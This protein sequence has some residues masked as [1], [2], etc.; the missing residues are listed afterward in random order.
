[1][2]A[3]RRLQT[4]NLFARQP[5]RI[6]A[7]WAS[8]VKPT[9]ACASGVKKSGLPLAPPAAP[10]HRRTVTTTPSAY[11]A[12]SGVVGWYD[13]NAERLA[14]A[15]ESFGLGEVCAWFV[16]LLPG[17]PGLVVD[18]GAGTGRDAA[19][20][21]GLGHEVI[22]VEPSTGFTAV[23]GRLH[24]DA[25]VTWLD[26]RLPSLERLVRLG[27]AADVV[28]VSAV[29]QHVAPGDRRRAF[30]KLV[31]VLRSGGIL[32]ITLRSGP[33]ESGRAMH[34]TSLAEIELLA[35]G[36]GMVVVEVSGATDRLG[37]EDVTWV[38]VAL[39]LPDDGTAALPLLRH[40][41]LNDQKSST[42]KLGLLRALCR[43]ADGCGGLASEDGDGHVAVPLG[44][45][46]V[47][48]LRLYLPLVRAGLPQGPSN[49]GPDGLGF[50]RTGFRAILDGA[51]AFRDLRVGARFG[52]EAAAAVHGA[53]R[54]AA[55][56][57]DRMPST[58][59][60]YPGG[61][62]IFP[63]TRRRRTPVRG[64]LVLDRP[65]LEAVGTMRVPVDLWRALRRNAAW[66]E[67]ALMF[68]WARLMKGYADG[69]G[70]PFDGAAAAAAMTWSDPVREV[71]LP[72]Q[73]ASGMLAAGRSVHCVWTGRR[74][75]EGALDIDHCL[76]WSAWPCG[77]LW[78]LMPAH[79]TV[80]RH[81]KRDR[82]PSRSTLG[83]AAERIH[84]WWN[85]AYL[86]G[87]PVIRGR[88]MDEAS[89]SLPALPQGEPEF[90]LPLVFSAMELQ[91]LRLRRD[92][93]VPEW[94]V[95]A[96]KGG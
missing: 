93:R 69:Q 79:P 52:R 25:K 43:T 60:T 27:V 51:A 61:E 21:A 48:W 22:A 4:E 63:V 17:E 28:L 20:L 54:D 39:R 36:A 15:Y 37:R 6:W 88:F 80:N 81:L 85:E 90:G 46:A 91:G 57:I 62:R 49:R 34:P 87:A 47:N 56:I 44:A 9:S 7:T 75:T 29:W 64:E 86:R 40:L 5:F 94:D 67:P 10:G 77:D 89:S 31:S 42:Y 50:A 71:A 73:I 83:A 13:A 55:D 30:R 68:E 14:A 12:A 26:D 2:Q 18:I 78:N 74:L 3:V 16:H 24:G 8:G 1:M 95:G 92:Q 76:P 23:G 32:A 70:R 84:A 19:W 33:S 58:Y 72:R 41:I 35:R 53:V 65:F 38:R 96:P 59:L 66:I 11:P 82:M 45:V